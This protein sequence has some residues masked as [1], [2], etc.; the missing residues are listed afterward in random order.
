MTN[1]QP[2]SRAFSVAS[3]VF[4]VVAPVWY[5]FDGVF[6]S[7]PRAWLKIAFALVMAAGGI[8]GLVLRHRK[9]QPPAER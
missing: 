9:Q 7:G 1:R 2:D 3:R 8:A 6:G 5:F 4:L